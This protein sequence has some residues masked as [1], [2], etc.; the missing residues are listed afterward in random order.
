MTLRIYSDS[1]AK[2]LASASDPAPSRGVV[3]RRPRPS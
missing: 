2:Q 3:N 1:T